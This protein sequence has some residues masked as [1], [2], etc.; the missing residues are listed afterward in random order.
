MSNFYEENSKSKPESFTIRIEKGILNKLRSYSKTEK[1]TINSV[2]NQLL[3]QSVDWDISAAKAGWIPMPKPILLE[4]FEKLS[5]D[6]IKNITEKHAKT[7]LRDM[8][9]TM[10]GK[11]DVSDWLSLLRSRAKT[12][13]FHYSESDEIESVKVVLRHDL[14]IK[15]SLYLNS[16]HEE[17]FN[18]LGCKVELDYTPNVLSIVIDKKYLNSSEQKK[19]I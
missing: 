9:L 10:K 6:E 12:S 8:L 13:N 18:E 7:A 1:M 16:F 3:S 5:E 4:I 19:S 11:C 2:I 14:G 15:F 17:V